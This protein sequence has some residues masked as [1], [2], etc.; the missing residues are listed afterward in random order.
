MDVLVQ[1]TAGVAATIKQVQE[2]VTSF[3]IQFDNLCQVRA[4]SSAYKCLLSQRVTSRCSC[5]C[6]PVRTQLH[7]PTCC[8]RP[9]F[10][11]QDMVVEFARMDSFQLLVATMKALGDSSMEKDYQELIRLRQ[12][13]KE[14]AA[15][16]R[17]E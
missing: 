9:Q 5:I 3:N 16:R 1:C 13:I 2:K 15:V 17:R 11:P 14:S 4:C 6:V 12:R 10:L 8:T 7:A